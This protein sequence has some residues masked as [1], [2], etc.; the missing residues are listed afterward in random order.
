MKYLVSL[1]VTIFILLPLNLFGGLGFEYWFDESIQDVNRIDCNSADISLVIDASICSEGYH[2]LHYRFLSSSG[3]Y[4]PVLSSLF[5]VPAK[6]RL[7]TSGRREWIYWIDDDFVGNS[8]VQ[9]NGDS[10]ATSI[11][12]SNLNEGYHFLNHYS[13]VN[14]VIGALHHNLIFKKDPLVTVDWCKIWWDNF[15]DYMES[16]D[17]E[18]FGDSSLINTE[19]I[20]PDYVLKKDSGEKKA[21]L[22]LIFGNSKGWVSDLLTAEIDYSSNQTSINLVADDKFGWRL[23][24]V[25]SQFRAV[26]LIPEH[27]ILTIHDIK[28]KCVYA[29]KPTTNFIILPSLSVGIYIISYGNISRKAIID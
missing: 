11:D 5:Y 26:G 6:E 23:E 24:R 7:S 15:F 19:I 25:D 9:M 10:I 27:G 17:L 2:T 13:V 12:L 14:N 3:C 16:R 28:G 8:R 22:N 20:I 29:E 21:K 18:I 4:G 1:T